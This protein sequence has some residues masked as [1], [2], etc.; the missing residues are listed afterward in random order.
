MV[1]YGL[2][3]SL[4]GSFSFSSSMTL[5]VCVSCDGSAFVDSCDNC[6]CSSRICFFSSGGVTGG[7]ISL[8]TVSVPSASRYSN[9]SFVVVD[10]S[11]SGTC[12]M[13]H[14]PLVRVMSPVFGFISKG[15]KAIQ[16]YII[17]GCI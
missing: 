7:R 10:P 12:L 17:S 9:T 1:F 8:I 3:C 16:S 14:V 11:D 4:I 15:P 5:M 13:I 2:F 6:D